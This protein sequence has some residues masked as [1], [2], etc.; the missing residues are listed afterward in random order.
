MAKPKAAPKSRAATGT[1]K[2]APKPNKTQPAGNGL[3]VKIGRTLSQFLRGATRPKANPSPASHALPAPPTPGSTQTPAGKTSAPKPAAKARGIAPKI[4]DVNDRAVGQPGPP[5]AAVPRPVRRF[6]GVPPRAADDSPTHGTA[7]T[8]G[9]SPREPSP[10]SI[11]DGEGPGVRPRH[12]A[13]PDQAPEE[14]PPAEDPNPEA[15]SALADAGS[16]ASAEPA[17]P[18]LPLDAELPRPRLSGAARRYAAIIEQTLVEFGVP[19]RVVHAETGPMLIRFG[20]VPGYLQKPGRGDQPSRRERV[21]AAKVVSRSDDLALAL[22]VTSLRIEAP[23]PGKT[24]I[25]L[26]I[27]NPHPKAVPL[28]PLLDDPAFQSLRERGVLPM[29]LGSDVAGHVILADLARLPH[30][31]IAG[32]TGSGKSVAVNALIGT[33][34]QTRTRDDVRVIVVDP[35]RVEFTWLDGVPQLL[36]PVVTEPEQAVEILGKV[37][38]EMAHRYDLLAAAGCRNR[39]AYNARPGNTSRPSLPAL[40]VVIDELADLMMLASD[41]VERSICRVAQLGRAAGI[42]LVVATQRPSVDVI[43][44]LIKANLPARLAFAVSS[45]VDS[46]TILDTPGAERLLGRGDFLYLS[47]D[48]MRPVRGQGALARDSWLK[49][50]VKAAREAVPAGTLD[51]EAERFAKLLSATQIADDRMYAKAKDL[52]QEH[53]K[54]SVSFLQRK[55]RVGQ[56]KAE[57]LV[58]RLR[59]DGIIADPDLDDGS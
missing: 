2:R 35:K 22:G 59:A 6:S 20:I 46:R 53:P 16:A 27:P 49:H 9:K 48:A 7:V 18:D 50:I 31:L 57:A 23:V 12:N 44:G 24:Y 38:T 28:P 47:P 25:G 15:R 56:P 30:L 58:E 33:L 41:D 55:L 19:V 51:P 43:T 3:A 34:L 45:L 8:P 11:E 5:K 14:D 40:V 39:L 26:E 42:H 17:D 21:R 10:L 54:I 52:A 36:T 32:A 13:N 37:E 29:A 4:R 1:T